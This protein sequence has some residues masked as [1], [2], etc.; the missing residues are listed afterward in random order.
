[1]LKHR[2]FLQATGFRVDSPGR[3]YSSELSQPSH[4]I[5]KPRYSAFFQT[6]LD[7]LLRSME[8]TEVAVCGITANGGVAASV[9]DT[10]LRDLPTTVIS[11]GIAS[12]TAEAKSR[13]LIELS[14]IADVISSDKWIQRFSSE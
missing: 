12:F 7:L 8:V 4:T 11:D 3:Q 14:S 1:L 13:A 9:R 10:H 5:T 2:P 6:P